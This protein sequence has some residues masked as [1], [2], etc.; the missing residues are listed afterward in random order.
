[1]KNR[2][3]KIVFTITVLL[4]SLNLQ[5]QNFIEAL[6]LAN[7]GNLPALDNLNG[8][9]N[10]RFATLTGNEFEW[11]KIMGVLYQFD[12]IRFG[13][14]AIDGSVLLFDEMQ[15]NTNIYLDSI[16]LV[17]DEVNYNIQ[18]D[19]FFTTL[20]K[21]SVFVFDFDYINKVKI[22]NRIFKR[23][24]NS[25]NYSNGIYEV[26]FEGKQVSLLKKYR[27]QF[28]KSS[29]NPMVN[30]PRNKIQ[31]KK[32]F[33]IRRANGRMIPVRIGKSSILKTLGLKNDEKLKKI[34]KSEKLKLKREKDVVKLLQYLEAKN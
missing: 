23:Y 9:S 15:K 33:Y 5:S 32:E 7:N 6:K 4:S 10:E 31:H 21:D 2:T 20:D 11:S 16:R 34:I 14:I 18:K 1:M 3:L 27:V 12:D 25:E 26:L 28:V 17:L 22:S 30:R 19:E 29:P 8:L 13:K 24:T